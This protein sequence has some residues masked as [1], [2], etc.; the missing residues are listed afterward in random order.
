[1]VATGQAGSIAGRLDNPFGTVAYFCNL[2]ADSS[3]SNPFG[4]CTNPLNGVNWAGGPGPGLPTNFFQAN[5]FAAGNSAL[6]LVAEGY[7]NYNG[8]QFDFRQRAWHG[9]QFDANYTWSHT[10]GL[11]SP[12]NWQGQT[13]TFTL[14]NPRL[15]Y[16]PSLFD[17]RH[18][19]N[20]NGTFDL[21]FGH[22][23]AYLS[24]N[25][26]LDKVVGGWTIG[27]IFNFQTGTP[28]LLGG[29]S[30]NGDPSS[31]STFNNGPNADGMGDGGVVLHG[32]TASQLQSAI[33]V[34]RIPGS[35]QVSMINPKYLASGGGA[36]PSYITPNTTPGTI[37]PP[38]WLHG[39]HYWNDDLS[40]SKRFPIRES[41]NFTF[42]AEMLNVF[43]HPNF[44]QGP[45][46]GCN[47]YCTS[48]GYQFPFIQ[49]SG[50]MLGGTTPNFSGDSPNEGARVIELRA[51]IEF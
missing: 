43:N 47:Y 2:V 24:N 19:F 11:T 21:P 16:G 37:A 44:Q 40:L 29:G 7:S 32:V 10:L 20:V 49:G 26:V 36:N 31:A 5:P 22:G 51:N 15:G 1:M 8:L 13:Y 6:Y 3:G 48:A 12:N 46:A 18:A 9:L 39:P 34:Y 4:P 42:Q 23:R 38:V 50:F 14:R 25:K 30:G 17:I 35:T 33:G 45:G 41:V 28:F 27:T